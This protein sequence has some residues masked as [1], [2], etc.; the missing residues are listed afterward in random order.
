VTIVVSLMTRPREEQ[1]L[2]GLVYSL[3]PKPKDGDLPWYKRPVALGMVVMVLV[4]GLNLL[5]L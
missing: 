3:T 2:R 4:I 5:F 1:E